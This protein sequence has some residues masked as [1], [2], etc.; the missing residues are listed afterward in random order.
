MKNALYTKLANG[1][2][3][4]ILQLIPVDAALAART[5]AAPS[6][7]LPERPV[8]AVALCEL[9]DYDESW[10]ELRP[11]VLT[12]HGVSIPAYEQAPVLELLV[13]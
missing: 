8:V 2:R 13:G 1:T 9:C 5:A 12:S 7:G 3:V 4:R 10:Q 6:D 11:V